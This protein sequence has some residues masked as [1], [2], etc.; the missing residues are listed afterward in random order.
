MGI[1]PRLAFFVGCVVPG[2]AGLRGIGS[3]VAA[4][5]VHAHHP[6]VLVLGEAASPAGSGP[7]VE[8]PVWNGGTI[9]NGALR[10][11]GGPGFGPG[12]FIAARGTLAAV[13]QVGLDEGSCSTGLLWSA[14]AG[15]DAITADAVDC[16]IQG[17]KVA[18]RADG[19]LRSWA[20]GTSMVLARL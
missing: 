8:M 14:A 16:A 9:T 5:G 10:G 12:G 7:A 20:W 17:D 18:G 2:I 13:G 6:E 19:D 1:Q 4:E 15:A 11:D 3:E